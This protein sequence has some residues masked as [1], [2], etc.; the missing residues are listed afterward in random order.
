MIFDRFA[1]RGNRDDLFG[2]HVWQTVVDF[3]EFGT[4]GRIV[5]PTP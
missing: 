3:V 5:L 2:F 4:L 1:E